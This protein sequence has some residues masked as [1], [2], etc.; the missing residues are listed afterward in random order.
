MRN[1]NFSRVMQFE[2]ID[3][4]IYSVYTVHVLWTYQGAKIKTMILA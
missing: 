4:L 1:R 2:S 3:M